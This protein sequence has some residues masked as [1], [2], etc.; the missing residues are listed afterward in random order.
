MK[1]SLEGLNSSYEHTEEIIREI[2]DASFD[3]IPS[4]KQRKLKKTEQSL[5]DLWDHQMY[6]LL[7]DESPERKKRTGK[8]E[9]LKKYGFKKPSKFDEKH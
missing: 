5:R 4:D 9:Y 3:G 7:N 1:S 2:E 8:K 6:Q